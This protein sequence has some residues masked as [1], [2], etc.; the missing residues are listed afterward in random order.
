MK[1]SPK[2]QAKKQA[3]QKPEMPLGKINYLMIILGAAV[4]ATSYG[5]MYLEKEVDGIFA[6]FI[7]PFTLLGS[8]A[9]IIFALLY[10]PSASKKGQNQSS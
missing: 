3:E 9:W 4:I 8:Y 1:S 7:S 6:L 5:A 10:R 2:K